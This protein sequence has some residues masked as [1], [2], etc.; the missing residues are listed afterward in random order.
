M[1]SRGAFLTGCHPII[2]VDLN[3]WKLELAK[4][5]GA[6]HTVLASEATSWARSMKLADGQLD[7]AIEVSGQPS[8]MQ[9]ALHAVRL[10]GGIA[11]IVGNARHGEKLE[12]DPRLLNNG[13]QLRG[14]WGGDDQPDRDSL[15]TSVSSKRAELRLEPLLGKSYSLADVNRALDELEQGTVA[16]PILDMT[17]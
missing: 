13:K 12:I 15:A 6:S 11:V 16:R 17:G 14:T 10:Q 5:F 8:V 7:F 3:P 4:K 1:R 9:Q 2:A